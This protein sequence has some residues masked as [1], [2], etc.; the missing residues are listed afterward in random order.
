MT[1]VAICY[2]FQSPAVCP[3]EVLHFVA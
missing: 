2:L 3:T 1:A